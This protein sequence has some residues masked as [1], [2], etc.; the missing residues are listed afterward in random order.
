MKDSNMEYEI[1]NIRVWYVIISCMFSSSARVLQGHGHYL[2]FAFCF[3]CCSD[4]KVKCCSRVYQL[5]LVLVS[6]YSGG[7]LWMMMLCGTLSSSFSS[8]A[9]HYAWALA[10]RLVFVS[11]LYHVLLRMQNHQHLLFL[12]HITIFHSFANRMLAK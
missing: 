3:W 8:S 4:V 12:F 1:W 10:L 2:L 7:T 5:F 9:G 11:F 6:G